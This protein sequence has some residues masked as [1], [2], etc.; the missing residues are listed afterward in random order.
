MRP[1][2]RILGEPMG[3]PEDQTL[4]SMRFAILS[5]CSV[6]LGV[7]VCFAQLRA[8]FGSAPAI[9]VFLALLALLG[10]VPFYVRL[11]NERDGEHLDA[12]LAVSRAKYGEDQC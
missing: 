4:K 11:K 12:L 10:L 2:A 6:I 1:V 9:V 7:M 3:A 8:A 5:A